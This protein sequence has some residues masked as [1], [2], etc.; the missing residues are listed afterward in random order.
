MKPN[1]SILFGAIC[2]ILSPAASQAATIVQ[3]APTPT[4]GIPYR[5]VVGMGVNDSASFS[6]H[7]GAWSWEDESLFPN[8]GDPVVGWT[9]TSDWVVI[10]ISEAARLTLLIERDGTVPWPGPGLPD[11]LASTA[12]MFP[13][14]TIWS[15]MDS[16][17]SQLHKYDNRSNVPWAEDLSFLDFADNSMLGTVSKTWD[18]PAGQYTVAMGSNSPATDLDRQG[19]RTTLTTTAV[20]EPGS[21]GLLFCGLAVGC[22]RRRKC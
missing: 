17:G 9:H 20:P 21:V 19:Y 6:R 10:T 16:D 7:V 14:F 1:R 4:T 13:S 12:S 8:P 2:S 11:R 3:N 15:G 18:L 5:W 22:L